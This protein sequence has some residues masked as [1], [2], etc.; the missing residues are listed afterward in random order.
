MR[1]TTHHLSAAGWRRSGGTCR[2]REDGNNDQQPG[3]HSIPLNHADHFGRLVLTFR[4]T[5]WIG[6]QNVANSHQINANGA[7]GIA[8]YGGTDGSQA[9]TATV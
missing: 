2:Q 9:L 7:L 6:Q 5:A 4:Q 3:F 8:M 1:H